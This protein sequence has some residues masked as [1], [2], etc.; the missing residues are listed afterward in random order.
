MDLGLSGRNALV[1][2]GGRGIGR[3]I[4]LALASEG[5]NVAIVGRRPE[6]E[7]LAELSRLGVR[8]WSLSADLGRERDVISMVD[9]AVER[10]GS[11]DLFV[12]AAG[13]HWHEPVT[14]LTEANIMKTLRLNLISNMIGCRELARP[15][16]ARGSGSILLVASTIQYMAAY[17]ESSYRVS[18][19]G[20]RVYAETLALE[21]APFGIRVN[22]LSPGVFPTKLS[23]RLQERLRDPAFR[24]R[25]LG[26]I[27]MRRLGDPSEC[28]EIAAFL[29]SD[30]VASYITGGDFVVDGGFRLRPMAL[31]D[32]DEI[33]LMNS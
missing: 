3:A 8:A 30:R 20:L 15:M 10:M 13:A 25:L 21:L 9:E 33:L 19:V 7:T 28:G 18:K 11:V 6:P 2:G 12:G 23:A 4:A 14:K 31:I 32:D 24:E 17:R 5:A 16:I 27:P 29:L 22:V 26:S 1:T